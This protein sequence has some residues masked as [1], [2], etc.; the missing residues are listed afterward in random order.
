MIRKAGGK[1]ARR[2]GGKAEPFPS[3]YLG[4]LHVIGE[5]GLQR[6]LEE[7][8]KGGES[9]YVFISHD[10]SILRAGLVKPYRQADG[11]SF[12]VL[13]GLSGRSHGPPNCGLLLCVF[14]G[15]GQAW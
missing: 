4:G 13:Q 3:V 10:T 14:L 7:K 8:R 9:Q 2:G 1:E 11:S 15:G 6:D 5:G 12:I